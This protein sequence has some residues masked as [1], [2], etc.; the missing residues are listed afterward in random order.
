MPFNRF[1]TPDGR[2]V[3][4]VLGPEMKSTGEVMGLDADFGTAF[5]KSQAAAFG[6]LPTSGPVFVSMANRD[7]RHDDLPDQG[8]RRPRLRDPRHRRAPPRCCAATACRPRWCASTSRAPGRRASRPP[9]QLIL[10]GEIDLVDQHPARLD[11]RRVGPHRRLRDPHRRDPR[12]HPLHH[13][14]PGARR[15][16]AGHRGADARRDRR[17][18]PPGLGQARAGRMTVYRMLFDHGL[19]R[20]DPEQAHHLGFA[21][22]ARRLAGDAR[23]RLLDHRRAVAGAGRGD[24]PA[25]PNSLGLA[26][27]FDKNAVGIDALGGA[28]LRPRRDRHGHRGG[29]ARQ[30]QAAALP[31]AGRPGRGQPDGLQQRRRRGRGRAARAGVVG[32]AAGPVPCSASTSARPRSCPTTTRPPSRP[33]TRRAR[34]CWRR[35]PTTSSSTSARPTPRACATCRRSR[36]SS[37]C[38]SGCRPP[39]TP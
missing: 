9:S 34:G 21:A 8:A 16:R 29:P 28:R 12:Q 36:S 37:R 32:P 26:A 11:R 39:P 7:K 22:T 25:L 24:G 4:T 10:A 35:T 15:R 31:A 6:S 2:Q 13:H 19:P 27:G 17:P 30:P 14:G 20:V 1:R 23:P 18:E 33:T 5:A 38:W 3:D